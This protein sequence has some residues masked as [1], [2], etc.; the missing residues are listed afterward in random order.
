MHKPNK[1]ISKG[2]L[3]SSKILSKLGLSHWG[4]KEL[5]VF[6]KSSP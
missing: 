4:G 2:A 5:T 1:A 3:A 6:N